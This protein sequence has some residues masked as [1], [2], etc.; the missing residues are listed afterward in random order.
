M[1]P[2]R[3]TRGSVIIRLRVLRRPNPAFARALGVGAVAMSYWLGTTVSR[4]MIKAGRQLQ[5]SK[6]QLHPATK[7]R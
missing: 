3:Y 4:A 5:T 6:A 2:F 7:L 1:R